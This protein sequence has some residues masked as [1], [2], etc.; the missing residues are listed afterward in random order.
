MFRRALGNSFKERISPVLYLAGI[1]SGLLI[2]ATDGA[3]TWVALAFYVAVAL[4]WLI[5]DTR[6]EHAIT[7]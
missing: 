7:R 2:H 5:P 3:T 1:V 6:L 4:M